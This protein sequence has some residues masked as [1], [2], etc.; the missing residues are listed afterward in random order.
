MAESSEQR[1]AVD[2]TRLDIEKL[3]KEVNRVLRA[4]PVMRSLWDAAL[5]AVPLV[6]DGDT[7]IL[8][9]LAPDMRYA[10]YIETA[11]NRA[12]LI[13]IIESRIG[14][15]LN[16][17]VIEGTTP[18]SWERAQR[19][20]RLAAERASGQ[21][22]VKDARKGSSGSWE[23]LARE[24]VRIFSGTTLRRFPTT[25]AQMLADTLALVYETEQAARAADPEGA[26]HHDRELNRA[27]DRLAVYCDMP[28]TVI[29]LE[30]LHYKN[31]RGEA[32]TGGGE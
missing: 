27:F 5:K 1:K 26:A 25:I 8:G 10:S 23:Y 2:L 13:E 14:H 16:L 21:Q 28:A 19:L 11:V 6:L 3:W 15:R 7:L 9:M 12:K 22:A 32:D 24:I 4:G 29:A 30:Y 18:E 20:D 17:R 31:S